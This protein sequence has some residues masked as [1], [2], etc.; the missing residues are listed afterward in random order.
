MEKYLFNPTGEEVQIL[1]VVVV[2]A[3]LASHPPEKSM[4]ELCQIEI[5]PQVASQKVT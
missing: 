3:T 5:L 4:K 1:R 2:G